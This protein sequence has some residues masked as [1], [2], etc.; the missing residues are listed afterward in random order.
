MRNIKFIYV[1]Y[2]QIL[3]STCSV[4]I[5]YYPFDTQTC[6]IKFIAWSY[7][8]D[9]VNLLSHSGIIKSDYSESS[10][11]NLVKSTYTASNDVEASITYTLVLERKPRFYVFNMILP[12]ILLSLLNMCTFILPL[13]SGERAGY[14]ITVFLSLVVFLTIIAAEFPKNSDNTSLLAV[15]LILMVS[16]STLYVILTIIES[17][18]FSRNDEKQPVGKYYRKFHRVALLL[19]CKTCSGRFCRK[20]NV[21]SSKESLPS[22]DSDKDFD[23][24]IKW[25]D[26]TDSMD[27]V[28]FWGGLL[29]TILITMIALLVLMFNPDRV[30]ADYTSY[31]Q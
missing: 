31:E 1:I 2:F 4:D 29:I 10:T 25:T 11:W 8:K 13:S 9:E 23:H 16:L 17:R 19:Q 28:F 21:A 30:T 6:S 15:Y 5:T 18:L 26:I 27:Y 12:V 3:V 24:E 22:S 14:S 20:S 7:T